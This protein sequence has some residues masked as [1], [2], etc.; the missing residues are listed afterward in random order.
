MPGG[1]AEKGSLATGENGRALCRW[2][3][4]E[5]PQRRKTF[6]SEYCV[7]EWRLRT[8]PG[9]LRDEVLARDRGVCALC[10]V[11]TRAAWLDVKR[12]RGS[13]RRKLLEHWGLKSLTRKTLWDADHI[14]PVAEGGGECD[15]E[16]I[17]T[18]CV[19]CHRLETLQ[20]RQR[21]RLRKP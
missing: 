20:L 17:R 3:Q 6:C 9:F 13:H 8:D 5:V 4:L 7:R 2:C 1:F 11:D 18:L 14:L 15:L 19:R 21:L 12:A 10:K 16:N